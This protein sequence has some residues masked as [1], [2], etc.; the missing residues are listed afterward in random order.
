MEGGLVCSPGP[1]VSISALVLLRKLYHKKPKIRSGKGGD[2][3]IVCPKTE[4]H[5]DGMK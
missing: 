3:I 5:G 2:A 1:A 4:N